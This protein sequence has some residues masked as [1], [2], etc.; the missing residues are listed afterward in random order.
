[1][2]LLAAAVDD[3]AGQQRELRS[4]LLQQPGDLGL[5]FRTR[6]TVAEDGESEGAGAGWRGAEAVFLTDGSSP[7]RTR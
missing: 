2:L 7:T 4:G 5:L 1:M 3:V 6:S